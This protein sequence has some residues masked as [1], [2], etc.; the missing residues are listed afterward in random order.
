MHLEP[1][2]WEKKAEA[3]WPPGSLVS[4]SSWETQLD[5]PRCGRQTCRQAAYKETSALSLVS[6]GFQREVCMDTSVQYFI[7]IC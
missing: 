1:V 7:C 6:M 2:N 4:G 3:P 5:K